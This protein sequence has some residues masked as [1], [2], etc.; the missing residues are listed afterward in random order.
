MT[1]QQIVSR[2]LSIFG[3]APEL[4]KILLSEKTCDAKKVAIRNWL[5][6]QLA[7]TYEENPNIPP[8]KYILRRDAIDLFRKIISQRNEN[9]AGYS[10]IQYIDTLLSENAQAP[11]EKPSPALFAELEHL[12]K[13]ITGQTK[14]YEDKI[15]SFAKHE[16]VK[17]AKLR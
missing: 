3:M 5:S 6:L 15:P 16:G 12:I 11:M 4:E 10:L 8:L 2:L 14:I 17:A 9:L 7:E 13:G 1:K